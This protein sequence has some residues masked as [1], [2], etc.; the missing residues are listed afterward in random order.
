MRAVFL[1]RHGGPDVLEVSDRPEPRRTE[2][3]VLLEVK[4][5]GLNHLDIWVRKGGPRGFPLPLVMGSDA[6]G[7]VL[8]APEGC[9]LSPG[10]EVVVYP[11]EGCGI[12]PACERGDDMLCD[13]FR[14]Y[15]AWRDGG[16]C[17][18]MVLPARN[19]LRKPGS[20]D[21]TQAAA[22]AINYITAWHMLTARAGLQAGEHVL[23]QA[24]GSGVSTAAIQIASQLGARVAATSST[25]GKLE[26]ATRCGASLTMDYRKDDVA[27]LALEWTGGRGVDVVF[28]HVGAPNWK[29]D[30]EALSKGGRLVFCGVTGGGEVELNLGPVYFKGQSILGSTMGTR[31]ELRTVLDLMDRG[32]FLPRV[33]RVFPMEAIADA[34]R[35]LESGEQTG[36]VVLEI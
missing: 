25:S 18:R 12:C 6:A 28:D 30:L 34:H 4:A 5:C 2:G 32:C 1:T 14:I 19:C 3:D 29:A 22:V 16:L 11:G 27:A 13:H 9:G 23:I 15:G 10:D 17:E 31:Q 35:Y 7:T 26:H 24:A 21:F 33:D 20:L 8:E 36:K